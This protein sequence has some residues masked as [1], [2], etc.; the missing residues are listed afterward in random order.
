M[1]A[2]MQVLTLVVTGMVVPAVLPLLTVV[3]SVQCAVLHYLVRD[4]CARILA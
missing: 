3:F 1:R 4:P 2:H